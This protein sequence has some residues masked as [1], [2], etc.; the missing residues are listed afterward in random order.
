MR[1]SQVAT[2]AAVNI[3]TVR[4]YERLGLLKAPPRTPSGYRNYSQAAVE[5]IRFIKDAQELGFTLRE[6]KQLIALRDP[7]RFTT[8]EAAEIT[9]VKIREI[10]N[11]I[12]RLTQMRDALVLSAANCH[13]DDHAEACV[14]VKLKITK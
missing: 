1:I 9:R 10:E 13:C 5:M 3:Q 4:L 6:I 11:K 8:A 14:L 12:A 7:A 2:Q